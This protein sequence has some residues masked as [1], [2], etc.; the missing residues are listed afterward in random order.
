[1]DVKGVLVKEETV[2]GAAPSGESSALSPPFT[3]ALLTGGQIPTAPHATFGCECG[4]VADTEMA[5]MRPLLTG[6]GIWRHCGVPCDG[7][8]RTYTVEVVPGEER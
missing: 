5:A 6:D 2:Y 3:S 8:E 4:G 1:M 7:C